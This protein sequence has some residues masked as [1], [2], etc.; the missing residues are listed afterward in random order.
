MRRCGLRRRTRS[1]RSSV[2]EVRARRDGRSQLVDDQVAVGVV[3]WVSV[4]LSGGGVN[5][6]FCSGTAVVLV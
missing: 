5:V 6:W 3:G 4:E 2:V 1:R